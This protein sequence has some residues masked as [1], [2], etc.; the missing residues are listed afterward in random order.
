LKIIFPDTIRFL[1]LL[2]NL[3][4]KKGGG[5]GG[6]GVPILSKNNPS[7][8]KWNCIKIKTRPFNSFQDLIRFPYEFVI[9]DPTFLP[10]LELNCSPNN[11]ADN[12]TVDTSTN[13]HRRILFDYE[14]F[15]ID[16]GGRLIFARPL[17]AHPELS[18]RVVESKN[19]CV[20]MVEKDGK[21]FMA[22]VF[23]SPRPMTYVRE[24]LLT[25]NPPSTASKNIVTK[26]LICVYL[27]V[28][29]L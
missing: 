4:I 13:F 26:I 16:T 21:Q 17:S 24:D 22:S 20:D 12:S 5:K 27:F 29:F 10:T 11:D 9:H 19:F 23:C 25:L 18:G 8:K 14:A 1:C 2:Q 7:T 3:R 15:Q 28:H 6:G